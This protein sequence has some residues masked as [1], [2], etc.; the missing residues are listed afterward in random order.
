MV[1]LNFAK[2]YAEEKILQKTLNYL[3]KNPEKNIPKL[4]SRAFL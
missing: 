4:A 2:K 1:N 3:A